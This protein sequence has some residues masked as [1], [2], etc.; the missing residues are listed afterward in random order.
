MI[1]SLQFMS[2]IKIEE[3]AIVYVSVDFLGTRINASEEEFRNRIRI[4]LIDREVLN[5][6]K[7]YLT[8]VW[9]EGKVLCLQV[10]T[11]LYSLD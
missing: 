4:F 10:A 5:G 2:S 3:Q 1:V 9:W 7:E 6:R 11:S 8:K